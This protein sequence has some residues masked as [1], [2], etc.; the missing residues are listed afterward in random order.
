MGSEE[1][2]ISRQHAI[3][4]ETYYRWKTKCAGVEVSEAKR[5]RGDGRGE[6]PPE[7]HRGRSDPG[8]DGAGGRGEKRA[9]PSYGEKRCSG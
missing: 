6:P 8:K 5:L 1:A 9:S 4:E 3:Q 2:D 7:E